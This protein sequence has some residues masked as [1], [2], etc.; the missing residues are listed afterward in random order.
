MDY[1]AD[2]NGD[3]CTLEENLTQARSLLDRLGPSSRAVQPGSDAERHLRIFGHLPAHAC[4]S[5]LVS[6][7]PAAYEVMS[8][9]FRSECL[10]AVA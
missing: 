7:D 9:R 10:G 8:Q 1:D 5:H 3:L 4:C 6:S 2:V